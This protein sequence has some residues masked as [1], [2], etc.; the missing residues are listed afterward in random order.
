MSMETKRHFN[1]FA[2]HDP[3]QSSAHLRGDTD[4]FITGHRQTSTRRNTFLPGSTS[5]SLILPPRKTCIPSSRLWPRWI[6]WRVKMCRPAEEFSD[7][8]HAGLF[9]GGFVFKNSRLFSKLQALLK[10]DNAPALSRDRAHLSSAQRINEHPGRWTG[11][12]SRF[13]GHRRRRRQHDY[14]QTRVQKMPSVSR[15]RFTCNQTKTRRR[16]Q[17]GATLAQ[18]QTLIFLDD[19]LTFD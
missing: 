7:A 13:R 16:A 10:N 18:A 2:N 3:H 12:P 11:N 1:I 4:K 19:D 5:M 17:R 8:H 9:G 6:S 14:T 15:S